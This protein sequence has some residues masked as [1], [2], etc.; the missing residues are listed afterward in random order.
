METRIVSYICHRKKGFDFQ[1]LAFLIQ[2]SVPQAV[3]NQ[4]ISTL[5]NIIGS[6][7]YF[8]L[9]FIPIQVNLMA[10]LKPC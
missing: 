10:A 6:V 9:N 7:V 2:K 5:L 1:E 4:K 8:I 3:I